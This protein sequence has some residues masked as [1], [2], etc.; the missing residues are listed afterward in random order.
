MK[1]PAAPQGKPPFWLL[2][3]ITIASMMAMNMFVPAL[4]AA[5][6]E[7][8]ASNGAMQATISLYVLGLS[9]GQLVYGPIADSIGR[10]PTLMAGLALYVLG[11]ALA[12]FAPS[13]SA[14]LAARMLQALGGCAGL[15]LGR[16][17]AR[18]TSEA[19]DAV[20]RLAM[21]N[22]MMM[23]G[24]SLAPLLGGLITGHTSW[25]VVFYLM[26]GIGLVTLLLSWRLLPET[27]PSSSR[28]VFRAGLVAS[29][30]RSLLKSRAFVYLSVGGGLT[31]T[32]MHAFIASAPFIFHDM[33]DRPLTEVGIY[34]FTLIFGM[35]LG[36]AVTSRLVTRV[37]ANRLLLCGSL[38]S[39]AAAGALALLVLFGH[40]SVTGILL[41]MTAL[42]CGA[43]I[44][45]PAIL[46]RAISVN[47]KL[48]GS[49]SGLYGSTQML[50]G[51]LCTTLAACFSNPA[52][53]AA[54]V[55]LAAAIIAQ[56]CLR[57]G[58]KHLPQEND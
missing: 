15:A 14:L 50:M 2:A 36:N 10:R 34:L 37:S 23:L 17:I 25:R 29:N 42:T 12:A 41:C 24:P 45:S 30:Y 52:L 9:L 4:P 38:F 46:T 55:L 57:R 58:L 40:L 44:A 1:F 20:R 3:V 39:L 53:G 13:L 8:Q 51:A 56:L 48:I 27:L 6:Q 35:S 28:Q 16:A 43:G 33:L 47:S 54:T 11:S 32:S 49:A 31:T 5:G 26:S 19:H 22:L 7:L 21:L 18:D